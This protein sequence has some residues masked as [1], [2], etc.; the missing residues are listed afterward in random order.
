[1]PKTALQEAMTKA[2]AVSPQVRLYNR[3]VE[4]LRGANWNA[5]IARQSLVDSLQ[6]EPDLLLALF[7]EAKVSEAALSYLQERVAE[8]RA[9]KTP[10]GARGRVMNVAHSQVAPASRLQNG[11]E[12][13]GQRT[14]DTQKICAPSSPA[15]RDEDKG[16][17]D[18]DAHSGR[19]PSSRPFASGEGR[20]AGDNP[21][22]L[23]APARKPALNTALVKAKMA[24][25]NSIFERSIGGDLKL[26]DATRI[27]LVNFRK[28]T[29]I[30]QHT[31]D[32]LLTEIEWRDD[33]TP[34][35]DLADEAQVKAILESSYRA[36]DAI[37]A[38]N[39]AG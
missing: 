35:R 38:T 29:M 12:D 17:D 20:N 31:A 37:G 25:A 8:A 11:E 3:A 10:G 13:K 19:A 22:T 30:A 18:A 21:V 15:K 6:K 14:F 33:S 34:L 9:T 4:L 32:R 24:S 26:G 16:R 39:H 5:Q 2:G 23:A 7:G 27:D 36:L 1:M 28:K